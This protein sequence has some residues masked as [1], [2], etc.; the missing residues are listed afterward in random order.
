MGESRKGRKGR[1]GRNNKNRRRKSAPTPKPDPKPK[2]APT[3]KPDPGSRNGQVSPR[4][5]PAASLN[6]ALSMENLL[7]SGLP[8]TSNCFG[9]ARN[10]SMSAED[11][12]FFQCDTCRTNSSY[13][14]GYISNGCLACPEGQGPNWLRVFKSTGVRPRMKDGYLYSVKGDLMRKWQHSLEADRSSPDPTDD[15]DFDH[16]DRS[17]G[18]P[19]CTVPSPADDPC[20]IKCGG[21]RP[22]DNGAGQYSWCTTNCIKTVM[23]SRGGYKYKID[24]AVSKRTLC[25]PSEKP[26]TGHRTATKWIPERCITGKKVLPVKICWVNT[27]G[28]DCKKD[29]PPN[30]CQVC[31]NVSP[32]LEY[33]VC[34][35][36]LL[37]W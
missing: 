25:L 18:V 1:K 15:G 33:G 9:I 2:P 26:K 36:C 30:H 8:Y 24:C 20:E 35:P 6:V 11:P 27:R 10:G 4:A 3:P 28:N 29:S 34:L 22:W 13:P 19:L 17:R 12:A 23:A 5:A 37:G 21:G 7:H 16:G 31:R 14:G 32:S